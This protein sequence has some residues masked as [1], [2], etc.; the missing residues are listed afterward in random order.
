MEAGNSL[1]HLHGVKFHTI[2]KQHSIIYRTL[3]I[4]N[5]EHFLF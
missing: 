3:L 5:L 4:Y 1:A 2:I